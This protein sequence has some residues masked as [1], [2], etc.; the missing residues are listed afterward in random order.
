MVFLDYGY[1]DAKEHYLYLKEISDTEAALLNHLGFNPLDSNNGAVIGELDVETWVRYEENHKLDGGRK[2]TKKYVVTIDIEENTD[3]LKGKA[4]FECDSYAADCSFYTQ[5][6]PEN[7]SR[8][9]CNHFSDFLTGTLETALP[10]ISYVEAAALLDKCVNYGLIHM[11]YGMYILSTTKGPVLK[12]RDSLIRE[13]MY[14]PNGY[15]FYLR[16]IEKM[17]DPKK[18][19]DFEVNGTEKPWY[20]E[21]WYDEDIISILEENN[22]DT[23]PD[24]IAAVKKKVSHIFDDKTD[25]NEQLKYAIEGI[26]KCK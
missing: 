5:D 22:L 8:E 6:A 7:I 23:S 26:L 13:L 14:S 12:E 10:H 15:E 16:T 17:E 4:I 1:G 9:I 3:E 24:T 25:R 11:I 19:A 2:M 21:R 20:V 18:I